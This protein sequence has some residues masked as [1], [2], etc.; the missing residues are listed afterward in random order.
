MAVAVLATHAASA[1]ADTFQV[2]KTLDTRDGHCDADCSLREAII[3]ANSRPGPDAVIVPAGTHRLLQVGDD[4]ETKAG[5]LDILDDLTLI[6]AGA[7]LT[8]IDGNAID[9][10]FAIHAPAAVVLD[11]LAVENGR[12]DHGGGLLNGPGASLTLKDCVVRNSSTIHL[13]GAGIANAAGGTLM[14]EGGI[15]EGN[16]ANT[17]GGGIAN[18]GIAHL[19]SC[20]IRTNTTGD[21]SY[22]AGIYNGQRGTLTMDKSTLS[23]NVAGAKGGGIYNA[24]TMTLNGCT[25]NNNSA[26]NGGAVKN[27][28]QSELMA[29]TVADNTARH[30]AGIH[31]EGALTL[32]RCTVDHNRAEGVAGGI[33]HGGES[34]M[35]I[36]AS[37]LKNNT[38]T[39]GGGLYTVQRVVLTDSTLANNLAID[40][41]GIMNNG[42]VVLKN[43]TLS[44]NAATSVGG[45]IGSLGAASL[46]GCTLSGNSAAI[47]AGITGRL[48]HVENTIIANSLGGKNCAQPIPSGG[49]N[50]DDDGSC[51]F[52]E[53][54][55][56][57]IVPANIA[58]LGDYG[59]ATA[60]HALCIAPG[61]PHNDCMA[62]SLAIDAGNTARCPSTDQRGA[63]RP[64]AAACD[65]GAFEA[66]PNFIPTPTLTLP[67]ST[68]PTATNTAVPTQ[69]MTDAFTATPTVR[70]TLRATET[71]TVDRCT[72]DC[73]GG[74][75]VTVNEIIAMVNVTLGSAPAS[76][77]TRGDGDRNGEITINEIIAAV[78]NA[79]RG[80]TPS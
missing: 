37:T 78:N 35:A 43:C 2:T 18:D 46:S 47:A 25:L 21:S 63:P 77:C 16:S 20:V 26:A 51:G 11:K 27:E 65:I 13:G 8:R 17:G 52:F 66:Q 22:G 36:V 73:D 44:G 40:A 6:G 45:A 34:T 14:L 19:R 38:A 69:T 42:E 23:G 31:S 41:A 71:A 30:G 32:T 72:G 24:G 3:A 29:C 64:Y 9:R 79:L 15:V 60:T 48:L 58:P 5:D 59:G 12:A 55:D 50:L 76:T 74:G 33:Y 39:Q 56:L 1:S 61:E 67:P 70:A 53:P 4:D 68:T 49:N 62:S 10:V 80:C 57:S 75:E 28:G 54:G 7:D